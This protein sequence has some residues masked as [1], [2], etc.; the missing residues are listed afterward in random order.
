MICW[1]LAWILTER[2]MKEREK[3]IVECKRKSRNK[4]R[5][6]NEFCV[7]FGFPLPY[8]L[9]SG[10]FFLGKNLAILTSHHGLWMNQMRVVR[11]ESFLSVK[12]KSNLTNIY[13]WHDTNIESMKWN[14]R[15][16][17]LVS[18][19]LSLALSFFFLFA[20]QTSFTLIQF[21]QN[22]I[23]SYFQWFVDFFL[24][25]SSFNEITKCST[26]FKYSSTIL[27]Y[28]KSNSFKK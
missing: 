14:H 26:P 7:W 15:D 10:L 12:S 13:I 16:L 9:I 6:T 5:Q 4:E 2:R 27:F 23:E 1:K 18:F 28:Q 25:P 22:R 24:S 21:L 19:F 20:I 17:P 11:M 8:I 3:E